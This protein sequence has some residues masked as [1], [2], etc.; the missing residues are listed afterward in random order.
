MLV[1]PGHRAAVQPPGQHGAGVLPVVHRAA[2]P[3]EGAAAGEVD[4]RSRGEVVGRSSE[5]ANA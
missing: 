2:Q 1:G 3:A 5:R 4:Q